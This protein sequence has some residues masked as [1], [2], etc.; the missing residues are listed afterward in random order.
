MDLRYIE[1]NNA[2]VEKGSPYFISV[3]PFI[4]ELRLAKSAYQKQMVKC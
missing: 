2:I 4:I 3:Y 1:I